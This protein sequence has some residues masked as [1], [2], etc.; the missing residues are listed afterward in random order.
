MNWKFIFIIYIIINLFAIVLIKIVSNK[1]YSK[2]LGIFY[3]YLFCFLIAGAYFTFSGANINKEIC[4]TL[5]LGFM[6]AFGAYFQWRAY[7]ISLSKTVLFSPLTPVLSIILA[8]IFL[9]EAKFWNIQL[10]IGIALSLLAMW[11]SQISRKSDNKEILKLNKKWLFF[12]L[13]MV[14]IF[15]LADFLMKLFSFSIPRETF[16]FG[17]YGGTFLSSLLILKIERQ[18]ITIL[19]KK[20]ILLILPLSFSIV[21]VAFLGY[22][23]FQLGGPVSL[24]TPLRWLV[25]TIIP[26]LFGWFIF[27]ER[28]ELS[29]REWLAFSLGIIGAV[30]IFLS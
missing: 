9:G 27:K 12:T 13:S 17:W 24:V 19:P 7:E 30:L 23:I 21:L 14:I 8:L 1:K 3:Q 16:L 4:L 26:I 18:K 10:I 22:W 5:M 28:K 29:K 2:A 15:G 11:L 6:V 25:I 20:I